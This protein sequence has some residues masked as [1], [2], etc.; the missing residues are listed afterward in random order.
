M[1]NFKLFCTFLT[2]VGFTFLVSCSDDEGSTQEPDVINEGID[3]GN[4]EE[5]GGD[6]P[7]NDEGDDNEPGPDSLLTTESL[8]SRF[9]FDEN[10]YIENSYNTDCE[11]IPCRTDDEVL[12][13]VFDDLNDLPDDDYFKLSED[14]SELL[15]ECMSQQGRRIE[16]KQRSSGPLDSFAQLDFEATYPDITEEGVT[17]AQVHNRGASSSNKPFFRLVLHKEYLET[18]IREKP[19]I[20][21]RSTANPDGSDFDKVEIP[22]EGREYDGSPLQVV[23]EKSEG[24]VKINVTYND[25][26]ILDE[27][28]QPDPN[29]DWVDDD[30]IRNGFYLKAGLYNDDGDHTKELVVR[31]T[32][33]IFESG[34]IVR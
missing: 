19:I 23:L 32:K 10:I 13:N 8:N 2:A 1:K 25:E 33:A 9:T 16:F 15:L 7:E 5:P 30:G 27:K 12:A 28:F 20:G 26:L 18:V 21:S 6:N 31:V 14:G 24:Y 11:S 34:D 4:N 17:I 3:N 29:T 22:F